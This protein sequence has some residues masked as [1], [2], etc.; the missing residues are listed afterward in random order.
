M[1]ITTFDM[2]F[3]CRKINYM[4][5]PVETF[6]DSFAKQPEMALPLYYRTLLITLEQNG[7]CPNCISLVKRACR[8]IGVNI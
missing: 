3:K 8:K 2:C 1:K 6:V 5:N 7:G 4:G